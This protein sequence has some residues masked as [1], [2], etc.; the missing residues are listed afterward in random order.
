MFSDAHCHLEQF[1]NPKET[2]E[3]AGEKGVNF[4]LSNS[5]DLESMEKCLSL[6]E[7][8]PAVKCALGLHPSNLLCMEEK[9]T[10]EALAFME[11][12]LGRAVA[13]GEIGLDF[14]HADSEEKKEKQKELFRRQLG[15]AGRFGKPVIVHSRFAASDAIEMLRGFKGKILFHWFSGSMEELEEAIKLGAFFSIGPAVEFG[16]VI[17][18][19]AGAVPLEKLLSETDA[20]VPFRGKPS[21]P[22]WIPIVVKGIAA[23]RG[24]GI[25]EI[26]EAVERNFSGFFELH[27]DLDSKQ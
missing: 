19:I 9:E 16:P 8:F 12:N 14:K 5:V 1:S 17:R 6:S 23:A 3:D 2:V 25:E 22:S 20:P 4:I 21:R 10:R 24:S 26:R 27:L 18:E 7:Q 11:A 13:V 15:I